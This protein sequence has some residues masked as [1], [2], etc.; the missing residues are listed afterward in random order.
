LNIAGERRWFDV[1]VL[2]LYENGN[3]AIG[4]KI[5][6]ADMTRA[7]ELNEELIQSRGDLETA[8]EEL[9]SSNEELETTNE[10]LQSTVEELETT[11]EE[12]QSTNEELETMNEELQSTNEELEAMNDELRE[13]GDQIIATNSF[14]ESILTSVHF[15]VVVVDPNLVVRAWNRRAEELWGLRAEEAQGMQILGLDIGLPLDALLQPI[16]DTIAGK[17][18]DYQQVTQATNRRGRS[19][20]CRVTITP[21]QLIGL[22]RGAVILMEELPGSP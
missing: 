20:Q 12:L 15:G 21:M 4:A 22:V 14:M 11:N 18:E 8:Y 5:I 3:R 19:I 1:Y 16:R 9:H 6:F 7:H 2:P 10:E 13:Q 17:L